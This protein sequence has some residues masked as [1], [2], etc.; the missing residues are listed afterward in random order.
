[1]GEKGYFEAV[2]VPVWCAYT[3]PYLCHCFE[4][5]VAKGILKGSGLWENVRMGCDLG[6]LWEVNWC[7]FRKLRQGWRWGGLGHVCRKM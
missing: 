3:F 2:L 7:C 6:L 4:W 5:A 1:M